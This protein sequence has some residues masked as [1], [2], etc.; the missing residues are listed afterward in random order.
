M[1]IGMFYSRVILFHKSPNYILNLYLK[2]QCQ[3]ERCLPSRS[4]V[5][6]QFTCTKTEKKD[7]VLLE[8]IF[9]S[10]IPLLISI[11]LKKYISVQKTRAEL[12]KKSFFGKVFHRPI[13]PPRL[14]AHYAS[15][16]KCQLLFNFSFSNVQTSRI[17]KCLNLLNIIK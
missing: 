14:D 17:S 9:V 2:Q 15:N 13:E 1:F 3:N 16:A 6:T 7:I 8:S 4:I 12:H 5:R 11:S 10:L